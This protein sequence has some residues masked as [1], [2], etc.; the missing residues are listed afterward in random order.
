MS[1]SAGI[2]AHSLLRRFPS[3]L[4][5]ADALAQE[6]RGLLHANGLSAAAFGV[7]LALRECLNNA[8]LHGNRRNPARQVECEVTCGRKW[9]RVRV[10]DQGEGFDWRRRRQARPS[11]VT[12]T[13]GRGLRILGQYCQRIR[14]NRRGN[15]ISLWLLRPP[16]RTK[17]PATPAQ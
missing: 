7:E 3:R 13:S 12:Q 8:I 15:Q 5:A 11:S 10:R 4:E 9:I 1:R 16:A 6:I 2:T 17:A 14:Y